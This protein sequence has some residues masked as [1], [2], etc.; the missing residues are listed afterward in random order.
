MIQ[1]S[2]FVNT[3]CNYCIAQISV[4]YAK[5]QKDPALPRGWSKYTEGTPAYNRLHGDEGHLKKKPKSQI[6]AEERKEIENKKKKFREFLS[7]MM[8]KGKKAK[9]QAWNESFNDFIPTDITKSR[10]ERK[11]EEKMIK[12][13]K[14]KQ[15]QET[16][17]DS[18]DLPKVETKKVLKTEGGTTIVEKEIHKK[19]TKLGAKTS[20]Q[21]HIKFGE[22]ADLDKDMENIENMVIDQENEEQNKEEKEEDE[23]EVIDNHRLFVMNLP[24][25]VQ[26]D[27]IREYFGRY[28][29]I[30][31][32]S[33][34]KRRGGMGTGFCFVRFIEPEAAINAYANLDK[35]I[36]QGRI[37]TIMPAS[38]KKEDPKA[39]EKSEEKAQEEKEPETTMNP[40]KAKDEKVDEKSSFKTTKKVHQKRNFDDET[41]WNYLFMNRDAVTEAIANKLSLKKGDILNKDEDNLA[42]RVANIETQVIKETK[43]WMIENGIDLK[44]IEGK[45]RKECKRSNKTILVK[46][47]SPLVSFDELSL[48]MQTTDLAI[49][50][51]NT[52][53]IAKYKSA[54]QAESVMKKMCYYRLHNIPLYLEYAPESFDIAKAKPLSAAENDLAVDVHSVVPNTVYVKNLNFNTSESKL[55]EVFEKVK[56]GTLL[57]VKI[58]KKKEDG[59]QSQGYGFV[60]FETE[61]GAK[62]AIKKLQNTVVDDHILKLKLA[63]KDKGDAEKKKRAE[64]LKRRQKGDEDYADNDELASTKLLIKN[65]AFEATK[66]DLQSLFK[67]AGQVKKVRL[68]KKAGGHTHRGFGFVEFVTVEDAKNAFETMQHSH[69]YGR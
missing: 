67:E 60:E 29:E 14:E 63:K 54:S 34:P 18:E 52:L 49:S 66:K 16:A 59:L 36:F 43:D 4:E 68:P 1:V 45:N 47:I 23:G 51:S 7:V 55:K 9:D 64:K 19:S 33:L 28:G 11:K 38:K 46:N 48:Y 41:N 22:K 39:Q 50:P 12:D 56:V 15:K 35:K 31:E 57:S 24:F 44:S 58:I 8:A 27:E 30:D 20:K 69:L 6:E 2:Y 10:R 37:L 42:V 3:R 5:T 13:Q 65:L 21:V 17:G 62:N 53:A 25:E 26:D 40:P 61:E 32:I